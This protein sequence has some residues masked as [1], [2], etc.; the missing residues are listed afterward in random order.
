MTSA[1]VRIHLYRR[2]D[3]DRVP[4]FAVPTHIR[5][6]LTSRYEYVVAEKEIVPDLT[7]ALRNCDTCSDWCPPYV[8]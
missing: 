4:V 7:D 1:T 5:D 3:A 8:P 2:R 6:E